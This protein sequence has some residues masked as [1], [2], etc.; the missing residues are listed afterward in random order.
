MCNLVGTTGLD[1]GH[2]D[3]EGLQRLALVV[4]GHSQLRDEARQHAFAWYDKVGR[5]GLELL[6][7]VDAPLADAT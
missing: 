7:Q 4:V 1:D 2:L 3:N 6:A 5:E